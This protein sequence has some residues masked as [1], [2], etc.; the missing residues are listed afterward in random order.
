MRHSQFIVDSE[1]TSLYLK[2]FMCS[3]ISKPSSNACYKI[4]PSRPPGDV[5][6][7]EVNWFSTKL[8]CQCYNNAD[9]I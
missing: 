8:S 4:S 2:F 3:K 9:G 5:F 7:L 6:V 1:I